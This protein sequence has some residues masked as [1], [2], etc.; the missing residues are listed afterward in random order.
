MYAGWEERSRKGNNEIGPVWEE[1]NRRCGEIRHICGPAGGLCT[2][3]PGD[4]EP[5]CIAGV[6]VELRAL[7]RDVGCGRSATQPDDPLLA[8]PVGRKA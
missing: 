5:W 4:A 6:E 2:G 7:R 3:M 1:F 8:D